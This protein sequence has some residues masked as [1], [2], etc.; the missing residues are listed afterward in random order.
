VD[1]IPDPLLLR[2][3]DK[4]GIEPGTSGFV[5]RISDHWN[6]EIVQQLFIKNHA[7]KVHRKVEA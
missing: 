3:S 2:K 6:A 7:M 5:A 1:P 4:P